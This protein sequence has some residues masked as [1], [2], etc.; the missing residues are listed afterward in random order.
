MLLDQD[1][2]LWTEFC[3]TQPT[4]V[5]QDITL[6]KWSSVNRAFRQ[7]LWEQKEPVDWLVWAASFVG[8]IEQK[9]LGIRPLSREILKKKDLKVLPANFEWLKELMEH[10]ESGKASA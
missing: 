5:S 10:L 8:N 2:E 1:E 9:A 7:A 4:K 3:S 6:L